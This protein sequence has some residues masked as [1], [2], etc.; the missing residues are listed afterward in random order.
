MKLT[1][2]P[3][4]WA[5]GPVEDW[6]TGAKGWL[7]WTSL[8]IMLGES[9]SSLTIVLIRSVKAYIDARRRRVDRG[10]YGVAP[11]SPASGASASASDAPASGEAEPEEDSDPAPADQQVPR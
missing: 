3:P 8:A 11:A 7:M 6:K 1:R 4:G 10:A 2:I 9:L 5:S